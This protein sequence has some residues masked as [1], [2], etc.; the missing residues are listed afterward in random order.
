LVALVDKH[1]LLFF[2][3]VRNLKENG[4]VFWG[5]SGYKNKTPCAFGKLKLEPV[6]HQFVFVYG[7]SFCRNKASEFLEGIQGNVLINE[8][9]R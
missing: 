8:P 5:E 4:S 3:P 2:E 7:G 9:D 1:L 6:F